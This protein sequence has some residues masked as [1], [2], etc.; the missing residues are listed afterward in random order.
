MPHAPSAPVSPPGK[1]PS[2]RERMNAMRNLPPFLRQ[3]WQTSPALTLASLCLRLLRAL[4]PVA[5]LYVGKLII[6][7]AVRL[8]GA[9]AMPPLGEALASGHLD[10]LLELLAL[11]LGIAIGSDLL[12]RVVNY[13]DTLL[14]ELFTN[15]TSVRLME[16]AAELDLEDFEDP[17]LQDKLDRARRQTMGRMNLMSQLLG[18][19]QDMVTVISFAAGLVAYA[20]WLIALLALA[21][22]PA[23]LGESHFNTLGY[24]LNYSWTPERRQLDYLRQVG[25]SVET[26]KEVKIFNLHRFLIDRYKLLAGRFYQA[27]RK[28][29]R[30]RALWGTVL[31]ALGT[32]GYYAAYAYIAWRTIRGDFS[33]GDL[34][35]LSGS[36]L[37]LRQLLE[38]LLTGFSQ[39]AGQALYL[40]DLFSFFAIEPEIRSRPDALPVPRPI[41]EGFV[42]EDVGFRY[43]DAER[44][45]VRHLDFRLGAGEVIALVGE[46]G[47]GK[48]TLVKLLAR[49]YDPDEG[50]ILLD[51]RDLRDYDLDDLRANMGVIFQDFVRYHLSAGE[52]IGVGQVDAMSDTA[53]IRD[54]ARRA[55]ADEV[56][57]ALP[58][59]YGQ[60]IGRRFKNGVDL[61]GG[62][63]QKIA[64]ARAY[65]RDAQVMILDEPTAALDARAEFEVFQRFKELSAQRTAV[66]ISHRFSSVRMADRI[67][68]LADGR[69]EASGTHAELM[70]QGGRYAELFELQAAGYR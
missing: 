30:K 60:L 52:N 26:A 25:A 29:A 13:A 58:G 47:A 54:A 66:L 57:D 36:F 11:E 50:R 43:P 21:L 20:P 48:T 38:G 16:H 70:A 28:L 63:W 49:L 23:F 8:A 53:R 7:E 18:Q 37:R 24:S 67:L 1:R 33:I 3:V 19:A 22:V 6:D 12:G 51:G 15:A 40:D 42:F 69:I 46:N 14:S 27:N 17:E 10:T 34:T 41:R 64:I 65:M 9:G 39:V 61:S 55:L 31:A 45:A 35:F 32:L 59:G 4:L 68:V 56:I 5:M 62:Q 2:F 44:W